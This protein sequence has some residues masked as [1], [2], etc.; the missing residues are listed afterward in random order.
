MNILFTICAR[1]GSKGVKSKNARDF[2]GYPLVYYTLS[3]Y[4]GFCR[5]YEA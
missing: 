1:A 4:D 5:N 2:L 3:V